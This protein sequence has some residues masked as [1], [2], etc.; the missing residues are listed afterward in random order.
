MLGIELEE[1]SIESLLLSVAP[2]NWDKRRSPTQALLG[3]GDIERE[4]KD[5]FL[6]KASS[7][8]A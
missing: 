1:D 8:K 5:H 3:Y 2:A 4:V 7:H 6:T